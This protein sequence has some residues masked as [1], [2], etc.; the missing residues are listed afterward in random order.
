MKAEIIDF[1]KILNAAIATSREKKIK[2][3]APT[4][5]LIKFFNDQESGL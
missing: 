2:E 3:E 4:M 5:L 1:E